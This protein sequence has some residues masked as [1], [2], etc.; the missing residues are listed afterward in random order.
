MFVLL[1]KENF[2]FLYSF[3]IKIIFKLHGVRVGKKF[4]IEGTPKLKIR[5]KGINIDIGNNISIFGNIDLRN[6]EIGKIIFEDKVKFDDN[7]RIVSAKDGIIKIGES[8]VIGP[9][10]IINGG[11]NVIIGKKVM[12]AKNISINANDHGFKRS[13]NIMDQGFSYAD[14]IIEDDVWLGANVCVNK[15]VV[16]RKGSVIGANAVVTQDTDPYSI[17]NGVP[18]K[19]MRERE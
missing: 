16:I 14:V 1:M 6:R 17:N 11:G 12:F 18:S 5:G 8:S 15:G 2:W 19:K 4:Y 7:V 13:M 9:N 3:L 10:T